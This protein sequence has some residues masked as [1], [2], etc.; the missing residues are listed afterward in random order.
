M[1]FELHVRNACSAVVKV[2]VGEVRS[3]VLADEVTVV[4]GVVSSHGLPRA[5]MAALSLVTTRPQSLS[6]LC[7]IPKTVQTMTSVFDRGGVPRISMFKATPAVAV[8]S[9][10][11]WDLSRIT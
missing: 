3:V 1:M 5:A 10:D 9:S 6:R 2:V 7:K 4:D 11:D 8:H